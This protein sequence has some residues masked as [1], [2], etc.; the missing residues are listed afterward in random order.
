MQWD[1]CS[2]EW[3][4]VSAEFEGIEN[5][6]WSSDSMENMVEIWQ[7]LTFDSYC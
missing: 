3:K 1:P 7:Y 2:A 4:R 5:R 6:F